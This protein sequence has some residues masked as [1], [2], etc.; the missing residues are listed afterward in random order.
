MYVVSKGRLWVLALF[1][2]LYIFPLFLR[3]RTADQ[4]QNRG[5][6]DDPYLEGIGAKFQRDPVRG[7]R[8]RT[9]Y[10]NALPDSLAEFQG[11][12]F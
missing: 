12:H 11:L 10:H 2:L 7:F 9:F 6:N 1:L 4:D 5:G 3:N 8:G